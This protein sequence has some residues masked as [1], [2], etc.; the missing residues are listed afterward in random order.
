MIKILAIDDEEHIRQV[1]K[2]DL[3]ERGFEVF[4]YHSNQGALKLIDDIEPDLV[5]LDI[6]LESGLRDHSGLNLV[7]EIRNKYYDM[8]IIL[9][10]A[11]D[12]YKQ[13]NRAIPATYY[14][15]KS[16]SS[17]ELIDKIQMA[18]EACELDFSRLHFGALSAERDV[19]CGLE[20]YFIE[21]DASSRIIGGD[22]TILLGN[23]GTGKSAIF[24]IIAKRERQHGSLVI[25]LLPEDFSYEILNEV[26]LPEDRGSWAKQN[27]YA[28]ALKYLIFII[29]MK[30]LS[31]WGPKFKTGSSKKIY[32]YLRDQHQGTQLNPI[33]VLISYLKRIEA[34]KIGKYEA[35]VKATKLTK[36]Y[37]LEEI[38]NLIPEI[39]NLCKRVKIFVLI[40]ELDRGWDASEDAKAF[41]GGLIQAALSVNQLSPNFRVLI[42]LRREL[43]DNIPSLY[44]D[45][46]KYRDVIEMLSWNK[47]SI[48][49]LIT[50]RMKHTIPGLMKFDDEKSW[51]F[52]FPDTFDN[53]QTKSFDYIVNRT[54]YRPR[55]I[56]NFCSNAL[57]V[58]RRK[59][60]CG[61]NYPAISEAEGIYS[62]DRANDI[63]AEY[64]FQY[65]GLM[66]IFEIFRGKP[67]TLSREG[68]TNICHEIV[69]GKCHVDRSAEWVFDYDPE[70]LIK[71]LW[72]VGFLQ[73]ESVNGISSLGESGSSYLG[74]H[75]ISNLNLYKAKLFQVHPMFWAYLG[76]EENRE[77]CNIS[78]K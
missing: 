49:K 77:A 55:E 22:K 43:Y 19:S 25:E 8:P 40:D 65:P 64:R 13:D 72:R 30:H 67:R 11:Y 31:K 10:T 7:P 34:V 2:E 26:I 17:K 32:S 29:V 59:K 75:Q 36:L 46:E 33:S 52:A 78:Q 3:V 9:F 15:V 44:G 54:L 20:Y 48:L 70:S 35:A 41:V 27:A 42:S 50:K 76:M 60:L 66:S 57:E 62:A 4:L 63:A 16:Y 58:T 21:T 24:K 1:L 45:S 68:L 73:A 51:S 61:I 12:H 5:I 6:K 71:V 69:L 53:G 56:I 37:K 38:K 39:V 47:S 23:R 18:L 74:P 28:A 14:V